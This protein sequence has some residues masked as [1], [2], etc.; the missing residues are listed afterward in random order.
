MNNGELK[1]PQRLQQ[2][3]LVY[4]SKTRTLSVHL[5]Y[6][7]DVRLPNFTFSEEP[8]QTTTKSPFSFWTVSKKWVRWNSRDDAD[9]LDTVAI[10]MA[11]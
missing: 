4:M 5:K 6:D 1:K 9:I 11:C 3:E 2:W 10:T 7:Y 8:K